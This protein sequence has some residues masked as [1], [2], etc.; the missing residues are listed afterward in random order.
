MTNY[1][2]QSYRRQH[3][4]TVVGIIIGLIIGLAIALVV[5]VAITK[6]S[7]PFLNKVGKADKAPELT[8]GQTADPNKPLY[9]NNGA[10]KEAAKD[11][12][13]NT[14]GADGKPADGKPVATPAGAPTAPV[15]PSKPADAKATEAP[16]AAEPTPAVAA[17]KP[18]NADDKWMYYLQAGAF[19]EQADAENSKAKL[20][21]AGFEASISDRSADS[22]GAL[23]RVRIGPFN[24]LETMN[25]VRGK[26][27][28]N[29][30]DVAV[31]RI[32]K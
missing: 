13:A 32:A 9:G 4:G 3:G 18:D 14:A 19:R 23:Y 29:G 27:S 15:A 11:I 16:K 2:Q 26:L 7:L 10:A 30:I 24:Q 22:G 8:A 28:D 5:A 17:A 6:T 20:A 31:V 12:A 25:K 21:L 1:A